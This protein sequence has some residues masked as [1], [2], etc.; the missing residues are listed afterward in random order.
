[1]TSTEAV[2]PPPDTRVYFYPTQGQSAQQQDRDRYECSNWAVQQSGFDPSSPP[3]PPHL[4]VVTVAGPPPGAG[5]A[6]G[7]M[8]GAVVG[9]AVSRPW[10]SGQGALVGAL[11][12]AVLGGIA[13]SAAAG[14]RSEVVGAQADGAQRAQIEQSARNYRRAMGACL[15]A[16]GYSVR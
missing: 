12:G 3:V 6:A 10:E 5:V 1:M 4:R 13:E 7:A 11:A 2:A 9:A 8:T 15:E 16:R 14:Q